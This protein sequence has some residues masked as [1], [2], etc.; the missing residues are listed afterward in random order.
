MKGPRFDSGLI[1]PVFHVFVLL[2]LYIQN[3]LSTPGYSFLLLGH[4]F[5]LDLVS[6]TLPLDVYLAVIKGHTL[7]RVFGLKQGVPLVILVLP[8]T[9]LKSWLPTSKSF[10]RV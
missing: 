3:H 4:P 2:C 1:Q 7:G 8:E 5:C 6:A 9:E 10:L